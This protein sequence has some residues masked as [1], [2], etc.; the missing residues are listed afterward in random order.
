MTCA[1]S[2]SPSGLGR[3]MRL[4]YIAPLFL[5]LIISSTVLSTNQALVSCN[6]NASSSESVI[7]AR[8]TVEI[9]PAGALSLKIAY[10]LRRSC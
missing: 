1:G 4:T 8:Y 5:L 9:T 6:P 10:Y 2:K 3:R 7:I